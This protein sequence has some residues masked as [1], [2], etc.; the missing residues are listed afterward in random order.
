MGAVLTVS[1]L[2]NI[3]MYDEENSFEPFLTF[4]CYENCC[5]CNAVE[6]NDN[7]KEEVSKPF[8]APSSK[9]C[10]Q[11]NDRLL[12]KTQTAF[13]ETVETFKMSKNEVTSS[14]RIQ[15]LDHWVWP[16]GL[17]ALTLNTTC[18]R[19]HHVR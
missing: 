18:G 2:G 10:V 6:K 9:L 16:R 15:L 1:R 3:S 4:K 13:R 8:A 12:A 7:E 17:C 5:T 11:P 19:G 14:L